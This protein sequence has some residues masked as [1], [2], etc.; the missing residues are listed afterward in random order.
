MLSKYIN[1]LNCKSKSTIIIKNN[2]K[3]TFLR[4]KCD[5]NLWLD[6]TKLIQ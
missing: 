4:I 5:R 2:T 3:I 1:K 6:I